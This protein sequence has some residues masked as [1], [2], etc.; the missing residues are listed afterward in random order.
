MK[1]K[2]APSI[3]SADFSNLGQAIRLVEEGGADYIHIDV[4][5]GHFVPNITIG[6]G[7]V[8][9][10]RKTSKLIFDVHLMIENPDNF[11]EDFYK[12]GADIITVHQ[13]ASVHLH[14]TIQKIK[15]YGIK[16]GVSLNPATPVSTLK[17]IIR[18]LDMVLLMSVNPGFG[19]QSLI[20]NVKYKFMDLKEMIKEFDLS[21]DLEIDGGVNTSNLKE[22]LSWGPNVIVAGSAIYH[23]EDVVKE[24][25]K[26]KDI[27]G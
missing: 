5:D 20:E 23:A 26:F 3:L 4:M 12:A 6:P 9:S 27:M 15:S 10:L 1:N 13:E 18:D 25:R 11:I 16:A 8:K 19:G 14:R 21:I 7:V 22:V 17:D 24:T 2:L